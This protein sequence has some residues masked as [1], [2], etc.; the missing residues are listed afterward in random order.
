MRFF[1]VLEGA[2][3]G[4][5]SCSV[6]SYLKFSAINGLLMCCT[7]R[8]FSSCSVCMCIW[9]ALTVVLSNDD[10]QWRVWWFFLDQRDRFFHYIRRWFRRR[11]PKKP[12][13]HGRMRA[14]HIEADR[15]RAGQREACQNHLT[16]LIFSPSPTFSEHLLEQ[17]LIVDF[18]F[19]F[20]FASDLTL[21][22]AGIV[23][24]LRFPS[25]LIGSC[26]WCLPHGQLRRTLPRQS[27]GYMIWCPPGI[28]CLSWSPPVILFLRYSMCRLF[29]IGF[30]PLVGPGGHGS[31]AFGLT[32]S[33]TIV[34]C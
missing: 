27:I 23:P 31:S 29:T 8:S 12:G 26:S 21:E 13:T 19:L 16:C 33:F 4:N 14:F 2:P 17:I 25:F 7:C 22:R 5:Y 15:F 1:K 20:P 11:V 10:G 28:S 9:F 18:R 34:A 24:A 3:A 32:V 6:K 30:I